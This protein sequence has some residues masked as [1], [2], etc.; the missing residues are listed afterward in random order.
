MENKYEF[1]NRDEKHTRH[2]LKGTEEEHEP[3]PS[4]YSRMRSQ[5]GFELPNL[6]EKKCLKGISSSAEYISDCRQKS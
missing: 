2:F 4:Q 1:S 5:H 6:T 3:P